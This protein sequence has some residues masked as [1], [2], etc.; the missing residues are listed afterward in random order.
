MEGR[1][2]IRK[3]TPAP[4]STPVS[5]KRDLTSGQQTELLNNDIF[6]Y[7]K[8]VSVTSVCLNH[9]HADKLA[10]SMSA[11]S[12]TLWSGSQRNRC[13]LSEL[14]T[15]VRWAPSVW[16]EGEQHRYRRAWSH[17]DPIDNLIIRVLCIYP[18]HTHTHTQHIY[19]NVERTHTS[20][21]VIRLIRLLWHPQNYSYFIIS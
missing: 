11:C 6:A 14:F 10:D 1:K 4:G 16:A 15:N 3:S 18:R 17:M 12:W 8:G 19:S 13:D 9:T 20:S 7:F 5:R 21:H 2:A